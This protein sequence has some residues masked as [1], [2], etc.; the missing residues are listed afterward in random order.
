MSKLL[1]A[2]F[3][4][5]DD[6]AFGVS[7]TL[8]KERHEG[9]EIHL[10]TLTAG[11][12]GVN[13]DELSDLATARLEEWHQSAQI[14]G[15]ASTTHLGYRDGR[16]CNADIDSIVE[17]LV[18]QI[19]HHLRSDSSLTALDFITFDVTGLSGHID[20]IVASHATVLA[21]HQLAPQ[22]PAVHMRVRMLCV[23]KQQQPATN[24]DWRYAPIGREPEQID[25]IIDASEYHNE[26]VQCMRAH[27]SQRKDCES[28][29]KNRGDT[30]CI[31]HYVVIE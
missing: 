12:A 17:Q 19:S 7:P 24:A 8:I 22:F 1:Y 5:P 6:E 20:H 10:I 25:E 23:T 11:E 9:A 2:I 4:H 18:S 27:H 14:I 31:N 16:L 3:A 26:V 28:H 13:P 15:A 30:L 29:L 21:Y